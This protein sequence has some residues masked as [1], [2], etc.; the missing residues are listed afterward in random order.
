LYAVAETGYI[1]DEWFGGWF[2][3]FTTI[4]KSLHGFNSG[5]LL[6]KNT[7]T[8]KKLFNDII[9]LISEFKQSTTR[10]MPRCW[11]Q[12]FINYKAYHNNLQDI[13]LMNNYINLANFENVPI[14]PEINKKII[15]NHFIYWTNKQHFIRDHMNMLL[16]YY[17]N[18]NA[19]ANTI[20]NHILDKQYTWNSGTIKFLKDNTVITTWGR[21][22]YKILN[23]HVVEASWNGYRHIV[24]FN[25]SFEGYTSILIGA[26]QI[27]Y[28]TLANS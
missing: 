28:G 5:A 2:F 9:T 17:I 3:D 11:E 25:N 10:G 26:N 20:I 8:M 23:T 18:T 7:P 1:H 16:E 6:F 14:S 21:G 19:N 24:L 4:D 13:T 22:V 27:V 15:L 12:P